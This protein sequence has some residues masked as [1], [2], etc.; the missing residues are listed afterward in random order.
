[1]LEPVPYRKF[2]RDPIGCFE[3]R[4]TASGWSESK[5]TNTTKETLFTDEVG[6]FVRFIYGFMKQLPDYIALDKFISKHGTRIS[7]DGAYPTMA[8]N[9]RGKNID[10]TVQTTGNDVAMFPFRKIPD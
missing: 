2:S 1:M 10:I 9:F 5:Y 6:E 3:I 8:V 7:N 4:M